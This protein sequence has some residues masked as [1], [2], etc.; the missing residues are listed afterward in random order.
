MR[1][2][3]YLIKRIIHLD[4]ANMFKI[5]K[6][7]SKKTGRN[8]FMLILDIIYCGIKYQAGYYDYQEFELQRIKWRGVISVNNLAILKRFNRIEKT[9]S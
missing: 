7:I 8:K 9:I 5:A 4:Y 6:S 1:R 2:I 3:I